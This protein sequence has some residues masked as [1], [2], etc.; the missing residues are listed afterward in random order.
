MPVTLFTAIR[1]HAC[2][3][4]TW[5]PGVALAASVLLCPAAAMAS[6]AWPSDGTAQAAAAVDGASPGWVRF[7][8]IL[9]VSAAGAAA[10][11]LYDVRHRRHLRRD[12]GELPRRQAQEHEQT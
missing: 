10:V 3:V 7:L 1:R 8:G 6:E 4:R 2:H 9:L 12:S 5:L 11:R